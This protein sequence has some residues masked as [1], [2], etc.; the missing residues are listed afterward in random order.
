M[1]D[2]KFSVITEVNEDDVG[3][4]AMCGP[5]YIADLG[6]PL[7][8][9]RPVEF[10]ALMVLRTP[11]F[12]LAEILI[13]DDLSGREVAGQGRRASKWDVRTEEF[14]TLE[15]AIERAAQVVLARKN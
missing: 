7:Q 3:N 9:H 15:E 4:A 11:V 2:Y 14:D 10:D 13:I 6:D 12:H 5:I 8:R 1:T